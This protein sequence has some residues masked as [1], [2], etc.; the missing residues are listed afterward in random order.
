MKQ[1][2]QKQWSVKE[3]NFS[4]CQAIG[5]NLNFSYNSSTVTQVSAY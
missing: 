4:N 3:E 2:L 1:S 5:E